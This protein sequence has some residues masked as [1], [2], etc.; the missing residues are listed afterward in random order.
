MG[1]PDELPSAVAGFLP[2]GRTPSGI[3]R[4]LATATGCR[5]TLIALSREEM[6]GADAEVASA[7][8]WDIELHMHEEFADEVGHLC[9]IASQ[10]RV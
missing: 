8:R 7:L 10:L 9:L 1:Y 3:E 6:G 2:G 4:E 5:R